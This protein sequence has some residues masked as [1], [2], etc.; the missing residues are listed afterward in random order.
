[1]RRFNQLDHAAVATLLRACLD[2]DRWVATVLDRRPYRKL[3]DLFEVAR[4]VAYP[5]T[6]AESE[7]ALAHRT[8]RPLIPTSERGDFGLRDQPTPR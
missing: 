7:S 3:D 6:G 2:V 1:M 4:D 8:P 5:L